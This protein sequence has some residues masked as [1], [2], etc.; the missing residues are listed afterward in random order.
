[1]LQLISPH[2]MLHTHAHTHTHTHDNKFNH[3]HI[4][5]GKVTKIHHFFLEC[6]SV[7]PCSQQNGPYP[8]ER[9][10]SHTL[11]T[12]LFNINSNTCL[13]NTYSS[14]ELFI[15]KFSNQEFVDNYHPFHIPS[16]CQFLHFILL[17]YL[18]EM[19]LRF[20]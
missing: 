12:C 4:L 13:P 20:S 2:H 17:Q 3:L 7:L 15:V 9:E 19:Q 8:A 14:S 16:Q 6:C 11:P 10:T 5:L 1:M 18:I